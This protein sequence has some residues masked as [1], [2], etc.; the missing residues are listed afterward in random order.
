MTTGT[1]TQANIP[2]HHSW[3]ALY[4]RLSRED[5]D[6]TE[7]LSISHQKMKLTEYADQMSEITNY[8]L[9]VDDGWTGTHFDRPAFQ[10]M[11]RDIAAHKIVGIIVKDL[12][13]LGRDNPK[14]GYYIHEF[15]PAHKI[16]F[17]AIDDQIDKKYYDFDTSSDM[18][19]D[20][21]NMFNGFYPR[22]ISS[23]VRST[24]RTKQRA[25]QFIGAFAC[26]GYRKAPEDHNALLI[27][28]TAAT[29]VRQI[30]SMYLA[31]DGQNTI[32]KKLNDRS[33]PCPSE[34][35]KQQGL[36]YHNGNRLAYTSY[37]TY[38]SIRNILRN[39]IYTGSMV[40]NKSFRQICKKKAITLPKEQWIIVPNTHEA[41]I[42][43]DTFQKVQ[44]LLGQNTRQTHMHRQIHPFA[45]LL[46]CGDC[47]RSMCRI[48]RNGRTLFRC[49]SYQ[50]YGKSACSAHAI[51]EEVLTNI[52]LDDCNTLLSCLPDRKQIILNE[53][54][55]FHTSARGNQGETEIL[56]H[57][58]ARV[59]QKKDH[60]YEDYLEELISKEELIKYK[61]GYEHQIHTLETQLS[62][63][64]CSAANTTPYP[65]NDW[66]QRLLET[67]CLEIADRS[68]IVEMVD[69]IEVYQDQT[70]KI[71]YRFSAPGSSRQKTALLASK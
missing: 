11:L 31:G 57:E 45:G 48:T 43:T 59:K 9:Y 27:D 12:S 50:R 13:R 56:R 35:K 41:I 67:G 25:G 32:A 68:L 16:R 42:D 18:M 21:K 17:I 10:Q 8:E 52:I 49:G 24:F 38:S 33:I 71:R 2:R 55:R 54:Q 23:K 14:A 5:G 26:Y 69:R 3:W 15:F 37:W 61:T 7:S 66:I 40:Q 46:K 4:I 64:T 70:L 1:W 62:L 28:E 29:V 60:I 39:E 53:E 44:H 47:G 36:N 63:L 20:V 65:H 34:Y 22:D 51:S 30:F 6:K 58:I 19:I